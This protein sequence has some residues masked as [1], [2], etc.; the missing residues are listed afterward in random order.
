MMVKREITIDDAMIA[1]QHAADAQEG[2]NSDSE[3]MEKLR[4]TIQEVIDQEVLKER[5]A[6]A[7]LC[8]E[9][10]VFDEDDPGGFFAQMIRSK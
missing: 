8:E 7:K 10:N 4:S 1:A 2:W 9:S 5:E 3:A 6:C